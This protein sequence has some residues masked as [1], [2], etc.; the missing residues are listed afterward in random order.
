VSNHVRR[1]VALQLALLT[2]PAALSA[3][4]GTHF[5]AL[6]M[7]PQNVGTCLPLQVEIDTAKVRGHRLV[8]KL[9]LPRFDGHLLMPRRDSRREVSDGEAKEKAGTKCLH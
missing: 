9:N 3:Q 2:C 1:V 7:P 4:A 6:S 5:E 8:M